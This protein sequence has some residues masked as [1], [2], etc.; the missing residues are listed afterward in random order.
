M[1]FVTKKE[2]IMNNTSWVINAYTFNA[3]YYQL[4]EFASGLS[5]AHADKFFK[6]L[7]DTNRFAKIE[8][9]QLP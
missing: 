1:V 9:V 3:G 4:A 5:H 2:Y 6:R 8:M 7:R